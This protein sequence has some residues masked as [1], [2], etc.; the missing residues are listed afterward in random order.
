MNIQTCILCKYTEKENKINN[1]LIYF[2]KKYT[3]NI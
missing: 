1:N 3:T 2:I